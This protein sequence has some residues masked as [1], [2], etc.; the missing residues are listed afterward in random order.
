MS[1][2]E[3]ID[4]ARS[5]FVWCFEGA[6]RGAKSPDQVEHDESYRFPLSPRVRISRFP[7][8]RVVVVTVISFHK[9][10]VLF[11]RV[12]WAILVGAHLPTVSL[13]DS[14]RFNKK[15]EKM[16]LFVSDFFSTSLRHTVVVQAR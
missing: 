9:Q 10:S 3:L 1:W 13:V 12:N 2:N 11:P 7:V 5:C 4:R 15:M 16:A 8:P 14:V 6:Y